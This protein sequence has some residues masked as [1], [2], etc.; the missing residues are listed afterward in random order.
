MT[1]RTND[2][3]GSYSL[4]PFEALTN[5]L[6]QMFHDFFGEPSSGS[7][8]PVP[9]A[10]RPAPLDIWE[11][12]NAYHLEVEIPGFS[13]ENVDLVLEGRELTIRGQMEQSQAEN[14]VRYHRRERR[15]RQFQ[16]SLML[17]ED[18]DAEQVAASM[19]D[20]VLHV[21]L[22]KQEKHKPRRIEIKPTLTDKSQ[23]G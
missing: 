9:S 19:E 11:D 21:T 6:D 13:M 22:T 16:R 12:E 1:T 5:R 20:G 7:V 17:P 10:S 8:L 14:T 23:Q 15:A 4:V 18:V 2:R 3:Q